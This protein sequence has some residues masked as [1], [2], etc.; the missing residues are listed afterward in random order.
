MRKLG[1]LLAMTLVL[2]MLMSM[3]GITAVAQAETYREPITITVFNELANYAGEQAGWFG[4]ILKDKFNITMNMIS[5][6]LDPNA[7]QT[8]MAS[9]DLGDMVMFGAAGD[10]LVSAINANMLLDWEEVG[11]ED[12]EHINAYTKDAIA[13]ISTFVKNATGKEGVWGFGQDIGYDR[14]GWDV[15]IEPNYGAQ[16]RWDA[17]VKAGYPKLE[18]IDD[19]VPFLKALQDA[20][21]VNANGEKVYAFGG[22]PDWEDCVMKFTWDLMTWYGYAEMDFL[23]V[24]WSNG[25][26]VNPL[27]EDSL[28]KKMLSVNNK[29][30][31]EGLFDPESIS[32]NWDSYSLKVDAGRYLMGL[33]GWKMKSY[34]SQERMDEGI[35]YVT[36]GLKDDAPVVAG[37]APFGDQ[38][39]WAIGAN[40]KYPER[41]L[42]LIDWLCSTEGIMTYHNGPQGLCWDY[43]ENGQPY[44]TE[45]G[46]KAWKDELN[47]DVPAEFGGG[48]YS[49][50]KCT[51]NNTTIL[52][53]AYDPE[54]GFCYN[55][56]AWPDGIARLQN[57]LLNEWS[58]KYAGGA[59]TGVEYLKQTGRF[60][61]HP[62]TQYAI[63]DRPEDIKTK[64]GQFAPIMKEYSWKCVYAESDEQFEALWK[65]MVDKCKAF[66][67]DDVVAFYMGEIQNKLQAIAE[68]R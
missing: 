23:G 50:G 59:K 68:G 9:G 14:T 41:V 55:H 2:A 24:N 60:S 57:R 38:R 47:T 51:L 3:I 32:Q 62:A 25:N 63:A 12:Y 6:N 52:Q 22:F 10:H 21:P 65:E 40:C 45:F 44:G 34:N 36:M 46:W 56:D 39:V 28:Y 33:W 58:E 7:Y 43:D 4:K 1:K 48:K 18:T 29:L 54:G 67:Y 8:R 17:Y 37:T 27:E 26:V 53:N 20:V 31:R 49:D 30:Y 61:L 5:T 15:V 42:E 64:R 16:V 13:K 19:L 66:G 11:Y 35:G